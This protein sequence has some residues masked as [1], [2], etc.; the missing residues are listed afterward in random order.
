MLA[1]ANHPHRI[2]QWWLLLAVLSLG[3]AALAA[4]LLVAARTPLVSAWVPADAF[5]RAL[6][7]HVNL[8]T[9]IWYFCMACALWSED[10]SPRHAR[11]A[12]ILYVLTILA[13]ASVIGSGVAGIGVPVLA[14]YIPYFSSAAFLA[15]LALIAIATLL[16][17][18]L[19]LRRPRDDVEL[20]FLCARWPF[21]M[22]TVYL[23]AGHMA[24]LPIDELIWGAGHI[25]QFGFITLL[26]A[27]WSRLAALAGVAMPRHLRLLFAAAALPAAIA[28]AALLS[29]QWD[30]AELHGLHTE[31]MRWL[32]WPAA[33]LMAIALLSQ[34]RSALRTPGLVP[35][36]CLLTAGIAAGAAIS[37][38]STMIPAHYHGTIGAFTLALM[39]AVMARLDLAG[40][41]V[42]GRCPALW[43]IYTYATGSLLL[44]AGL[45]WSGLL[46][47]PR[48][49]GF[50]GSDADLGMALAASLIGLGGLVTVTGIAAFAS[51]AIPRILRL[52]TSTQALH[53][54]TGRMFAAAH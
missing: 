16:T 46:G 27:I 49:T 3:L 30:A 26:M 25:L 5:P 18:T 31:L 32:N 48:K 11:P 21:L 34:G 41:F 44:I 12:A 29:G 20:G 38:Q 47:A 33:G 52:C 6:V 9:L 50:I 24:G 54:E 8:A 37:S 28:P 51:L 7:V 14:N 39:T 19:T 43:P 13:V 17:G 45:A 36:I 22:A 35:S 23:V 1:R 40:L 2:S 15:A 53:R 4:V 10:L 42:R